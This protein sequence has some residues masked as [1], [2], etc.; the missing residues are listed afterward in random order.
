MFSRMDFSVGRF[1]L[2]EKCTYSRHDME[3]IRH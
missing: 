2:S 1:V 3:V